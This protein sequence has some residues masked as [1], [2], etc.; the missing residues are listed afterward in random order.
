MYLS[1]LINLFPLKDQ[2]RFA[3]LAFMVWLLSAPLLAATI[4]VDSQA[5]FNT[6]HANVA[7]N[8]TII[9]ADGTYESIRMDI[10]RDSM[11]IMSETPGG[12]IFNGTSRVQID[13][14][15][16]NFI[17]FQYV[18]GNIGPLDVVN[19]RGSNILFTQVN[20]RAYRCYKYLRVREESQ[21]VDITYCNFENRLTV[22]DQNILSLLVARDQPGYHRVRYCSFKNFPG[23]GNDEGVEPIRVGVSSQAE[24]NSRSVV[25]YCYF[26][27]CDGDGE[28]ISSKASQ[29]V[30]RFNTFENNSK[31]ELVLRHGSENIVYGNFFL[32]GKGGVRVREGQ[33]HYIYN[34][35]FSDLNDRP[36]YLQ[37]E[38]SDPLDNINIAFNL[39]VDCERVRLGGEAGS[40]RPTGVTFSNNIFSDPKD[41]NIFRQVTGDE[42]W[43]G[44]ITFGN[45]GFTRPATGLLDIDPQLLENEAGFFG[46]GPSSPAI[47]ATQPGFAPLPQYDGIDAI[48]TDILFDMLG[49]SRPVPIEEKDLGPNEFPHD[50]LIQPI[51]TEENTGPDYDTSDPN[52]TRNGFVIITDA[53]SV[54]PNPAREQI[55]VTIAQNVGTDITIDLLSLEGKQLSRIVQSLDSAT[56]TTVSHSLEGLPA[57]MYVLRVTGHGVKTPWIQSVRFMKQ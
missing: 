7:A 38:P 3:L 9:W 35:Y 19:I 14:D 27:Q 57:G 55:A 2:L 39:F 10:S 46:L 28:I 23:G 34:N 1:N 52:S 30:Y 40:F 51:A 13:G 36:I 37:N 24:F 54:S 31:A 49:Q 11:T 8:D 5:S 33:D 4:I 17:G 44:N 42:T 22:A 53:V 45:L 47:D 29:N 43:I 56:N 12:T 16:I 21:Y 26:T 48:D 25:E 32:S 6:A 41:D 20:I 50:I 15:Y 18:G